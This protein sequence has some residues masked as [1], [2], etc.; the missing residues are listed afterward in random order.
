MKNIIF[1]ELFGHPLE[2]SKIYFMGVLTNV[3]KSILKIN[4]GHNFTIRAVEYKK[5][6]KFHSYT[7]ESSKEDIELIV[8]EI[9]YAARIK[10]FLK[11]HKP[12]KTIYV[13]TS[14]INC[15][16]PITKKPITDVT[17]LHSF[18]DWR[19]ETIKKQIEKLRLIVEGDIHLPIAF[20]LDHEEPFFSC[21]SYTNNYFGQ[22]MLKIKKKQAEAI[23][24]YLAL[25]SF[26]TPHSYIKLALNSFS[27][28]YIIESN[29]LE[30]I[31][32][33]TVLECLFNNGKNE[34]TQTI[35]RGCAVLIGKNKNHS[36]KIFKD[37]KYLYNKRSI[38][39]HQGDSS[40]ITKNDILLLKDYVRK[41]LN[42][43]LALN[44]PKERLNNLLNESGFNDRKAYSIKKITSFQKKAFN[45]LNKLN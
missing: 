37:I 35:A 27:T 4:F 8:H 9:F 29:A 22:R 42:L 40:K 6:I 41:C 20:F 39:L 38:L 45:I 16:H 3:N 7:L 31:T 14:I 23:N 19:H 26:F 30:F 18:C 13:I 17:L 11:N 12:P 44:L 32:L 15:I 36:Q 1:E 25:H 43:C 33:V 2:S 5:Y 34:I 24:D 28:S 21:R 10:D